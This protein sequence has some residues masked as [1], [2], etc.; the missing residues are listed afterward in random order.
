MGNVSKNNDAGDFVA[1]LASH[2]AQIYSYILSLVPNFTEADDLLQETTKLM[3]EKFSDFTPGTNFRAWGKKI[4]YF[5]ILAH[6]RRKK[7]ENTFSFDEQLIDDLTQETEK[8]SDSS[9]EYLS[10]LAK[11]VNK[12]GQ[13]DK[14]LLNLRYFENMA[15]GD[16][17]CRLEFSVQY[18]Y[19]N[20]S[21]IHQLLLS[22]VQKQIS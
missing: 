19:R 3:W 8:T 20:I 16:I 6:C 17:S 10:S 21:R 11:C 15:V 4:A 12:L 7:K 18:I 1:L 22:C 2:Q 9:K 14:K 5:V 13:K